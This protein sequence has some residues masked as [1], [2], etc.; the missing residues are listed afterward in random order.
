[1]INAVGPHGRIIE[2]HRETEISL[3]KSISAYNQKNNYTG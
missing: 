2:T 3:K 1:M